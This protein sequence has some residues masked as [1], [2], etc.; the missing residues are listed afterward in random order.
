MYQQ[1]LSIIGLTA[2]VLGYLLIAYE[3]RETFMHLVLHRQ[4]AI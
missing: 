4:N 1:W 3:W 2:E